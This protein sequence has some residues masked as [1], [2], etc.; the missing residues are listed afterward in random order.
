M[1]GLFTEILN[2]HKND[3][4]RL[5]KVLMHPLSLSFLHLKW[6][7]VKWLY[8]VMILSSH[9]IYSVTYSVYIVAV[10]NTLCK[11]GQIEEIPGLG[12]MS[13]AERVSMT[14]RCDFAS[15]GKR[16]AK[17]AALG[18]WVLLIVFNIIYVL[19]EV[20][21][22]THLRSGYVREWE[23]VLNALTIA[24]FPLISFHS[25]PFHADERGH[26]IE[27]TS[28][29]FHAAGVGVL[30]TWILQMFLIGK[31]PRFGKYVQMLHNVGWSF[32]NFFVAYFALIVGFGLS[33][34]VLFP[35]E[36]SFREAITA[37]IKVSSKAF[38]F[39]F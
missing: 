17:N 4:A 32:F 21:K 33:F 35:R 16:A 31:V 6:Q 37:P 11:P 8:Y 2:M 25:D 1:V 23:S 18:S 36:V 5:E 38:S 7:Q 28:W 29:Q 30:T 9:F 14:M 20:T 13:W 22:F 3:P 26:E 10:F 12:E 19:K 24:S 15:E 27:M 39:H 34:V